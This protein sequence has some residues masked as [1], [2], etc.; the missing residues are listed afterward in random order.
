MRDGA[1]K[2]GESE[3]KYL[4]HKIP[5]GAVADR[6]S[7]ARSDADDDFIGDAQPGVSPTEEICG[8]FGEKPVT[9]SPVRN[10]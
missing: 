5:P 10:E 3:E 6:S 2:H 4:F 1:Q 8:R 9:R 7:L